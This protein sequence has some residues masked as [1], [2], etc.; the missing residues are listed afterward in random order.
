MHLKNNSEVDGLLT[1]VG[2][3]MV[4]SF[5]FGS[6]VFSGITLYEPGWPAKVD[7]HISRKKNLYQYSPV[8]FRWKEKVPSKPAILLRS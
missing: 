8:I 2:E 4:R 1:L 3:P 7:E 5:G 6:A